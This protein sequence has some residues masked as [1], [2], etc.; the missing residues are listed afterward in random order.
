KAI[1][2]RDGTASFNGQH[3]GQR[4]PEEILASYKI[5]TLK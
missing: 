3:S 5:G 1:C 4:Q 2:G